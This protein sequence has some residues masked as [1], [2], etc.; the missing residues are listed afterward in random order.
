ML[1]VLLLDQSW[2]DLYIFSI[3]QNPQLTERL[4]AFLEHSR[5]FT[6]DDDIKTVH[7]GALK[8]ALERLHSLDLDLV[9]YHFLKIISFLKPGKFK[10]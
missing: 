1:Q 10:V 4:L 2:S 5:D 7:I 3:S 9:E 8:A 6:C